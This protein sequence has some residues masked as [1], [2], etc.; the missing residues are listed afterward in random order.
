MQTATKHI[1]EKKKAVPEISTPKPISAQTDTPAGMPLFLQ[2]SA[3]PSEMLSAPNGEQIAVYDNAD[4]R[5]TGLKL[6]AYG[7]SWQGDIFIGAGFGLPDAP[8]RS[9]V[10]RHEY[11]HA[12][13]ARKPGSYAHASALENEAHSRPGSEPQYAANPDDVLGWWWVVPLAA[14]LYVLLRP[15]VANAPGPDDPVQ[16]SVSELQ[17]AGEALA[18][19]AVPVGVA[20]MLGRAGYGVIASFAISGAT[21]SVAYRGVQDVGAGEFSGVEAYVVDATTGAVIGTVSGGVLRMVNPNFTMAG[22]AGRPTPGLVHLTDEA[23]YAGIN[24]SGT[25][26]GSQGIYALPETVMSESVAMRAARATISPS[27]AR[28][29][30]SIPPN[31][32]GL[33][34][35]PTAIGPIS[36]YQ[37]LMGVYRAPAGSIN[38][39]TGEFTASAN[40]LANITGQFWPYGVDM[41]IWAGAG[42][43]GAMM[44]PSSDADYD[45]GLFSITP[46]YDLM[47][48]RPDQPVTSRSDGPFIFV[49]PGMMEGGGL[50]LSM[51]TQPRE[52]EEG[53]MSPMA[54]PAIILVQP[55]ASVDPFMSSTE[56]A[57]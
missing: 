40:R 44:S 5:A 22:G 4:S 18:I 29:G 57:P 26:R 33:F 42:M 39:L 55:I 2:R 56:S 25:L 43:G 35:Q 31:A 54:G 51:L 50:D 17:V 27:N 28:F 45:R 34:S 19:F 49:D 10:L 32:T 38:M 37:R 9:D 52:D 30:V 46:V 1:P 36:A 11:V 15:N 23:G 48:T 12:L 8:S 20:G 21:S 13:Q 24:A 41:M 16:P 47:R 14:G 6:G 3:T 53:G 7:Y